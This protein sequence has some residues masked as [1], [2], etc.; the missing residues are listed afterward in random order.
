MSGKKELAALL[1][2]L[3]RQGIDLERFRPNH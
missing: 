2:D 3:E 1:R